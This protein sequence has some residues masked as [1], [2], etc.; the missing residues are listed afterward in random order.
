MLSG[1]RVL[2]RAHG[3]FHAVQGLTHT[4]HKPGCLRQKAAGVGSPVTTGRRSERGARSPIN[5]GRHFIA[6]RTSCGTSFKSSDRWRPLGPT[7]RT[8]RAAG[9]GDGSRSSRSGRPGRS[10]AFNG[11]GPRHRTDFFFAGESAPPQQK[12]SARP[13]TAHGLSAAGPEN[14]IHLSDGRSFAAHHLPW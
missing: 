6:I 10:R 13:I 2:G 1:L 3:T 8:R 5:T 12:P 4:R 9:C 11:V 14:Q 7:T